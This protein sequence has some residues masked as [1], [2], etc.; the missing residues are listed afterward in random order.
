M[1]MAF[2]IV[3]SG[4]VARMHGGDSIDA[5][6]KGDTQP[7]TLS[8]ISIHSA[9]R[10]AAALS[11]IRSV[12]LLHTGDDVPQTRFVDQYGRSFTFADFR[13]RP[14]V[15]AFIYTR[16]RDPR[17]CPLISSKF[18]QLQEQFKN[19][20]AHLVEIT[21]DPQYDRGPV[22]AKYAR[23]F[24]ART[25]RWTIG[26]GDPESVLNFAASF[27]LS[28]FPDE[29]VGLIHAERT[30]II[31]SHG[32][33]EDLI[34]EAGWSPAEVLAEIDALDHRAAS[35]LAR[36][37]LALSKA[38][39]SLCGNRVAGFSGLLDLGIATIIFAAFGWLFFRLGRAILTSKA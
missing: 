37:D 19:S 38:A 27:G 29:R 11:P 17:M 26:T 4:D 39:V 13:G 21:L 14:L 2:K 18:N 15:L 32:K 5:V 25:G 33:I 10:G 16:C 31:D 30:A 23:T 22:L 34:D 9:R 3:P 7:W 28:V 12:K 1:A 6:V 35:P 36:I 24:G 20:P 8:Q